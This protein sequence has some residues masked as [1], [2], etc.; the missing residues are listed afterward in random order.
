MG[1]WWKNLFGSS[2]TIRKSEQ[3]ALS[4]TYRNPPVT[5]GQPVQVAI[6]DFFEDWLV[7]KTP[8][9]ALSYLSVKANACI[10]AFSGESA[11]DS[12]IRLRLLQHMQEFN[13]NLGEV[14]DLDAV[15][16]GIVET[17]KG[18]KLISQ[19]YGKQFSVSS[20]TDSLARRLDC[21]QTY[22]VP[23]AEELPSATDSFG[24][25][26]SSRT[27]IRAEGDKTGGQQFFMVWHREHGAWKIVAWH[28]EDPMVKADAPQLVDGHRPSS[29]FP[30]RRTRARAVNSSP[31]ACANRFSLYSTVSTELPVGISVYAA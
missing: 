23:M 17:A 29:V 25:Y 14:R 11:K 9:L 13:M 6:H 1:N 8:E 26:Y 2:V 18:S 31:S 27:L 5:D 22:S 30:D 7:R 16:H 28:L 3:V 10:A 12:L 4:S 19:E 15:L 21:R 24:D 20:I